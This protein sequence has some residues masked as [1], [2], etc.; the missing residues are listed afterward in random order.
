MLHSLGSERAALP[1]FCNL[2]GW[3]LQKMK[4]NYL[5]N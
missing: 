4:E 2:G 3:D 1:Y 5:Q